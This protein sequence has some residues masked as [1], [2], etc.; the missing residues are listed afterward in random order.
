MTTEEQDIEATAFEWFADAHP[1]E[2][3]QSYPERFWQ[4]FHKRCPAISRQEMECLL[5]ETENIE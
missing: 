3:Y 2:A 1:H 4:H 5:H